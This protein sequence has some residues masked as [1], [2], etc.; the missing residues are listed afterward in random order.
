MAYLSAVDWV[1][2]WVIGFLGPIDTPNECKIGS[3]L[4]LQ[5]G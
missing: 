2:T 5:S 4:K 1:A 3:P